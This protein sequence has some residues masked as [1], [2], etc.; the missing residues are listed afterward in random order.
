MVRNVT[1]VPAT[2]WISSRN[3]PIRIRL[4]DDIVATVKNSGVLQLFRHIRLAKTCSPALP[5]KI[6]DSRVHFLGYLSLWRVAR[7]NAQRGPEDVF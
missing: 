5:R 3:K 4:L 7:K 2:N 6:D 1:R